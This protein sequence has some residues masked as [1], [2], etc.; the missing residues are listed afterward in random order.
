MIRTFSALRQV[1]P[2]FRDPAQR[3]DVPAHAFRAPPAPPGPARRPRRS[4]AADAA[5]IVDRLAA[6]PGVESVGV[7][8]RQRRTPAGW[9]R[10]VES[11]VR[12]RQDRRRPT[13]APAEGDSVC[14]AAVLRDDADAAASPVATFDWNDVYQ[15]RPVALVSENLARAEWGSAG[16][17]LGQRM[18]SAPNRPAGSEVVGVVKD[19]HHNGLSRARAA[20]RSSCPASRGRRRRSSCAANARGHVGFPGRAAAGG[21]V[22]ERKPLAG[23]R[24][25]AGRAVRALDGANVDDAASCS[26]SRARWRSSSGLVGIYGVVSYAVAQ[27]R[28]EIGIRLALGAAHGEVRRMFVRMRWCSWAS[29]SRSAWPAA[30]GLTRL[31]ESQLFGISP[32]DPATHLAV[33]LALVRRR[34]AGQLHLRAEGVRAGPGGGAARRVRLEA[35]R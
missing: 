30:A 12:R 2:G 10:P 7:H 15:R 29:A 25:D 6:V 28:R 3:P 19:V 20:D 13:L 4:G 5:A 14:L 22:G 16:A 24:P 17:A 27:R 33:A 31:M 1:D 8:G 18:A 35:A 34:R 23:K 9:R 21:L 32:L 26:R 11:H